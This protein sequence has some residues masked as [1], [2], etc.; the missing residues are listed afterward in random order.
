MKNIRNNFS[1]SKSKYEWKN[2]KA[3]IFKLCDEVVGIRHFAG[4]DH[5]RRRRVQLPHSKILLDSRAE[6]NRLLLDNPNLQMVTRHCA[7]FYLF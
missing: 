4:L 2:A 3:N 1:R 6:N 5:L 7:L